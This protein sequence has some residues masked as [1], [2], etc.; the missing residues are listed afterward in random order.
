V[1]LVMQGES[2]AS[3][4]SLHSLNTGIT[5]VQGAAP[6][7][8]VAWLLAE[9]VLR[10]GAGP[11]GAAAGG[12]G[13]SGWVGDTRDERAQREPVQ[14]CGCCAPWDPACAVAPPAL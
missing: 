1:T 5:Y 9:T 8:P 12:Q 3:Y 7:G 4:E 2:G 6:A 14:G 13:L 11:S 10:C